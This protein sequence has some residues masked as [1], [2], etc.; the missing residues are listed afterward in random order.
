VANTLT[1][2]FEVTQTKSF[3]LELGRPSKGHVRSGPI[4]SNAQRYAVLAEKLEAAR[5]GATTR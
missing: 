1:S 2:R 5:K 4:E 3:L